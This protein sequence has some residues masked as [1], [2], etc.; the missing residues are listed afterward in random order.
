[1]TDA[2]VLGLLVRLVIS[3]AVVLGLMA[4][5]AKAVKGRT[6]SLLG[7]RAGSATEVLARQSLAR[8]ASVQVVR[9]GD[10]VIVLGVTEAS[11]SYLT[12]ADAADFASTI[13]MRQDG[14]GEPRRGDD[15]RAARTRFAQNASRRSGS[16][17]MGI[18]EALRD[19][20][21]RR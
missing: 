21:A 1:M 16:A 20:T 15:Q 6:G 5:A 10:R 17:R 2:S 19:R 7:A 18:L 4:L 11:V 9:L 12:E 8:G 3:L 14:A 13:D